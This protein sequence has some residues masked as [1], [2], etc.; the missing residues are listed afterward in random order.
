MTEGDRAGWWAIVYLLMVGAA[1]YF[2]MF[3]MAYEQKTG[4]KVDMRSFENKKFEFELRYKQITD[5]ILHK[6]PDGR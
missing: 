1:A 3:M 5:E 2:T 4:K 6:R